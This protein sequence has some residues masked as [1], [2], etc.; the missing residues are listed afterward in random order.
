MAARNNLSRVSVF[1]LQI[2]N[3]SVGIRSKGQGQVTINKHFIS[4]I[5]IV[6]HTWCNRTTYECFVSFATKYK[7][8]SSKITLSFRVYPFLEFSNV[9]IFGVHTENGSF[10]KNAQFSNLRVSFAFSKSLTYSTVADVAN[11]GNFT[12]RQS[13]T[14]IYKSTN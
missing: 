1:S 14:R 9:S 10:F 12:A 6:A 5:Y 11:R 7:S 4:R 2:F 3:N 8:P 13:M